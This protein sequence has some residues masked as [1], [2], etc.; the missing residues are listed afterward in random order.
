M[1]Y[2]YIAIYTYIIPKV[3]AHL[4]CITLEKRVLTS[5]TLHVIEVLTSLPLSTACPRGKLSIQT[6]EVKIQTCSCRQCDF[7]HG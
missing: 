3:A 4:C 6:K 2:V 7:E 5:L 1:Y